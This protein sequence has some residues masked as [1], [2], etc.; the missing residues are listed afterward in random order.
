MKAKERGSMLG[1]GKTSVCGA[2]LT[3]VKRMTEEDSSG[4]GESHRIMQRGQ[5]PGQPNGE[6]QNKECTL[7]EKWLDSVTGPGLP[8]KSVVLA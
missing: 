8:R 3:S 1:Q 2:D 7:E 5:N 4:Q 6:F